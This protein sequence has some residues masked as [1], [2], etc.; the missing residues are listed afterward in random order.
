MTRTSTLTLLILPLLMA[1]C[2]DDGTPIGSGSGAGDAVREQRIAEDIATLAPFEGIYDLTGDWRGTPGDRAY[3]SISAP[4]EMGVS[5]VLLSDLDETIDCVDIQRQGELI[6]DDA[7]GNR[8]VFLNELFDFDQGVAT[9]GAD[10]TLTLDFVD[11]NDRDG[12]GERAERTQYRAPR[13][14]IMEL[15]PAC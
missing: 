10:R 12:D 6:V 3:L 11:V 13:I 5:S 8:D 4:D 15:P 7:L 9:L 14:D 1:A 2:S